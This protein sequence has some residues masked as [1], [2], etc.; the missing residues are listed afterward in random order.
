MNAPKSVKRATFPSTTSPSCKEES[1]SS[2]F[3]SFSAST[4]ALCERIKRFSE[5]SISIILNASV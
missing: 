2:F 4:T 3:D 1:N 5:G